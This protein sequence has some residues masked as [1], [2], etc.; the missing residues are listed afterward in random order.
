M[1]RMIVATSQYA[2]EVGGVPRLLAYFTRYCPTSVNLHL[3]SVQQQPTAFYQTYDA[4]APFPIERIAPRRA[5]LTSLMF[6]RRLRQLVQ[7]TRPQAILSGVAYPTAILAHLADPAR[8]IPIV[9][10]AHSE[11][12]TIQHPVKRQL[13]SWALKGAAAVITVSQFTAHELT[14][15]GVP[16]ERIHIIPPGIEVEPFTNARPC[17]DWSDKWVILT[18]AR[19][20]ARKGQ[21][22]VIRTLP[23]LIPLVPQVH[24]LIA[25]SGP[26]EPALRQLVNELGVADHVTFVGRVTDAELPAYYQSCQAFAMLTRPGKDEVEGFG[27]S[28]LEAAAAAKPVVAGRAGGSADAIQPGVTGFLV[29]PHDVNA[30][31]Q[32]LLTLAQDPPLCRQM[33]QAGQKWV[34]QHHTAEQFA[35]KV[36]GVV[37]GVM[38]EA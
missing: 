11:D 2:P 3:L 26:D 27:I 14:R 36:M 4:A 28:F 31:A 5:G 19:L 10:Y 20:I 25:G 7:Q 22:T 35:G 30:A 34:Q 32:A 24:Y 33:G 21:D 18:V 8:R 9:V 13:L 12:V 17:P 23:Q 1:M 38:R 16:P 6:T 15:L 37:R 29:D